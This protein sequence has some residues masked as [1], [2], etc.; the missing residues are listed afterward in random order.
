[1]LT[2]VILFV[3]GYQPIP[4]V[5]VVWGRYPARDV[6]TATMA[7]PDVAIEAFP[8]PG[9]LEPLARSRREGVAEAGPVE[10]PD[11]DWLHWYTIP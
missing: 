3:V 4:K 2:T 8:G 5:L 9:E 1:M 7:V 11:G 6:Q 10:R